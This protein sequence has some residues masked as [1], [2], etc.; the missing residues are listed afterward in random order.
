MVGFDISRQDRS[1]R[2]GNVAISSDNRLNRDL[3]AG[4]RDDSEEDLTLDDRRTIDEHVYGNL[5]SQG[6]HKRSST[7]PP[8]M[9]EHQ[10]FA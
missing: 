10:L 6:E 9:V 2:G 4:F 7:L 3:E 8:V 1:V 5:R